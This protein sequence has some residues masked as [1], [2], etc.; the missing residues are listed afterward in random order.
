[1]EETMKRRNVSISRLVQTGASLLALT[2][3]A[4][5]ASVRGLPGV[6][7]EDAPAIPDKL[8]FTLDNQDGAKVTLSDYAGKIIVLEWMNP[9]CPFVQRH[10]KAGTMA[11]LAD[12]YKDKGVVW[13][14]INS[15]ASATQADDQQWVKRF[16][17]GY[18][19]LNDSAGQV[20]RQYGAKTTPHL[21]IIQNGKIAYQGAI[22]ND[23]R[24]EKGA[25]AVNYVAQALEEILAGKPVSV[26]ETRPY[27]CTVKYK[28]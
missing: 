16:G 26:P 9:N 21:F 12:K 2:L 23:P 7:A 20:A 24:G 4:W 22:D 8:N 27:G 17:L 14:A 6:R 10:Y 25:A 18:P 13:L 3:V 5:G 11:G 19:I 1:M 15:T 28:D